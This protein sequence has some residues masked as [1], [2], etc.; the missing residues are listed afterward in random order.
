MLAVG[1]LPLWASGAN[2]LG[3][4]TNGPEPGYRSRPRSTSSPMFSSH[5]VTPAT[6]G[7]SRERM[8]AG[9]QALRRIELRPTPRG[10][11]QDDDRR[12]LAE[13]LG[14]GEVKPELLQLRDPVIREALLG[15]LGENGGAVV[16]IPPCTQGEGPRDLPE[17]RPSQGTRGQPMASSELAFADDLAEEVASLCTQPP[18][19]SG[20]H[21]AFCIPGYSRG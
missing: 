21:S 19:G 10:S 4:R 6:L 18:I 2:P 3:S 16:I 7:G 12:L 8:K 17:H 15:S 13:K 14:I 11:D 20:T 5:R 9:V 1:L